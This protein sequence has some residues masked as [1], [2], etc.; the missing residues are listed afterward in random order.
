M[1]STTVRRGTNLVGMEEGAT[2]FDPTIL[3]G[4]V[5]CHAG[6]ARDGRGGLAA[7]PRW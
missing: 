7:R 2:Q 6:T 4:E 3:V 1:S 5:G